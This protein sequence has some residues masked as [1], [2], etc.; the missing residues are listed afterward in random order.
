MHNNFH[1][2]RSA[3]GSLTK[4]V[5]LADVFHA[6]HLRAFPTFLLHPAAKIGQT[7]DSI[8]L[9]VYKPDSSWIFPKTLMIT[10]FKIEIF[11][12]IY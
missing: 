8:S 9:T 5:F 12:I 1:L 7:M 4:F 2:F 10:E 3:S 6:F 11:K